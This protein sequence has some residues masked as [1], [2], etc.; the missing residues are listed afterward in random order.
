MI[1]KYYGSEWINLGLKWYFVATGVGSIWA[2]SVISNRSC[3]IWYSSLCI[4]RSRLNDRLSGHWFVS[5]LESP[6]GSRLRDIL[7]GSQKGNLKVDGLS[8]PCRSY[9]DQLLS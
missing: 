1:I 9:A 2:V 5:Q 3:A 7:S 6:A 8:T 4:P